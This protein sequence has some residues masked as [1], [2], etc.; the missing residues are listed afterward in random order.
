MTSFEPLLTAE[1]IASLLKL[2]PKTV[3]S[4]ARSG[5]IPGFRMGKYWRFRASQ[6]DEWMVRCQQANH[7]RA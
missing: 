6:I 1:E 2:H 7:A 3:L 4:M 5:S